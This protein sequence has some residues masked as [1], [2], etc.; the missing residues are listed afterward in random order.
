[1]HVKLSQNSGH[2]EEC[3]ILSGHPFGLSIEGEKLILPYQREQTIVVQGCI[4]WIMAGS[5]LMYNVLL[6]LRLL[7]GKVAVNA[8]ALLLSNFSKRRG[9]A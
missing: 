8:S 5:P 9:Q 2:K 6:V 4:L 7:K 1:M 3:S